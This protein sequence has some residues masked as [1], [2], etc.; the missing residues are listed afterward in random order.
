MI[1]E[2]KIFATIPQSLIQH[3]Q[4][5]RFHKKSKFF[6]VIFLTDQIKYGLISNIR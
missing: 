4:A 2:R 1:I 6:W 5:K 3:M